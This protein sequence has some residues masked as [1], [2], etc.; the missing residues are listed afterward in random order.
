VR[1]ELVRAHAAVSDQLF[2]VD[3]IPYRNVVARYGP[4]AQECVVVGAHYDAAGL[5]PGADDNASGVAALLELASSLG[6]TS[7][8]TMVE[9]VTYTLEEAPFFGTAQMGSA[10]HAQ[11]L[12]ER[13]VQGARCV[14]LRDDWIFHRS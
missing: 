5:Y 9:L 1:E 2:Q 7:V 3:G 13:G 6:K 8:P 12:R 11:A 4:D 14:L 10:V